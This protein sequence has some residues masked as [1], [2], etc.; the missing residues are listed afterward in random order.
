VIFLKI[1]E[2]NFQM[3]LTG[4]GNNVF[5][6]FGSGALHTGIRLGKT[7]QTFNKLGE[8]VGVLDFNGNTHNGGH[9]ELHDLQIVGNL[10]GGNGSGFHKELID[11]NQTD[12]VT[13]GAI[14]NRLNETSHH[15]NGALDALNEQVILLSGLIVGSLDAN[16]LSR[17]AGTGE[18]TTESIETTLIGGR[19]HLG[20]VQHERTTG[21]TV[22]DSNGTLVVKRTLVERLGAILLSSYW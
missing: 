1:L 2:T 3:E 12:N 19:H 13:G 22:T 16:L 18:D 5:T 4:T 14:F 6:S 15:E 10:T 11:T 21:V 20:N 9:G 8:I 7:L 17:L